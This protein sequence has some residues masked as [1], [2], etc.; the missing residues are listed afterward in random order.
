MTDNLDVFKKPTMELI[1]SFYEMPEDTKDFFVD[2]I[3]VYKNTPTDD[4]AKQL[5]D[6][7]MAREPAD[8]KRKK[9]ALLA[10]NIPEGIKQDVREEHLDNMKPVPKGLP[11]SGMVLVGLDIVSRQDKETLMDAQAAARILENFQNPQKFFDTTKTSDEERYEA[12]LKAPDFLDRFGTQAQR[13]EDLSKLHIA[14]LHANGDTQSF[15]ETLHHNPITAEL[16]NYARYTLKDIPNRISDKKVSEQISQLTNS[17]VSEKEPD[18]KEICDSV[19][20]E[21]TGHSA[22]ETAIQKRRTQIL[23]SPNG[24]LHQKQR[25]I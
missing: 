20:K 8:E 1:S 19:H 15:E 18:L 4:V 22:L 23:T 10:K 13:M 12:V 2:M 3:S 14:T 17:L 5:F 6:L 7:V 25:S 9:I 21:A 11:S 16:S 24:L